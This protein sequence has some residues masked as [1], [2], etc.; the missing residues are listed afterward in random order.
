MFKKIQEIWVGKSSKNEQGIYFGIILAGYTIVSWISQNLFP[1]KYSWLDFKISAQGGITSNPDGYILWNIGMIL[2][3]ILLIPHMRYLYENLK[4]SSPRF[5]KAIN[6]LSI[7]ACIGFSFVGVFPR[8]YILLHSIPAAI[9]L[10]G[11]YFTLNMYFL[12]LIE[13]KKNENQI[14]WSHSWSFVFLF[15]P[16][17]IIVF[18]NFIRSLIPPEM[19]N[20]QLD[21]RIYSYPPWQWS[22]LISI[23]LTFL[24]LYLISPQKKDKNSPKAS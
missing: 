1:V 24:G 6:I 15:I 19:W 10:Y 4:D 11:F 18:G 5:A 21:P 3:G 13:R 8:E 2:M 17:N 9:A 22:F 12:L 14:K 23:F 16:L 7:T 20:P